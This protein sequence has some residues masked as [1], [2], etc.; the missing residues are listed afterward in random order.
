MNLYQS[1]FP[2][3][4]HIN[5]HLLFMVQLSVHIMSFEDFLATS[6]SYYLLENYY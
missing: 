2:L 4:F 6:Q 3:D 1:L 5:T